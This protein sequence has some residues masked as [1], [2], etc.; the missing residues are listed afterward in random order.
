MLDRALSGPAVTLGLIIAIVYLLLF[1]FA[2]R[3]R[4]KVSQMRGHRRFQPKWGSGHK[5]RKRRARPQGAGFQP[6]WSRKTTTK[7][8]EEDPNDS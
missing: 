5:H 1:Y 2:Q 8:P 4:A 7:P 6:E 3:E